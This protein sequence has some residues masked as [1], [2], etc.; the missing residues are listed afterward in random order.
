MAGVE[1]S[2]IPLMSEMLCR[3]TGR[4]DRP[5]RRYVFPPDLARFPQVYYQHAIHGCV[6]VICRDG[7]AD[8]NVVIKQEREAIDLA[9]PP[10]VS[11]IHGQSVL[12]RTLRGFYPDQRP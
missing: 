7:L 3:R 5:G 11:Q 12:V 9:V 4:R 6:D 2:P 10:V 1:I 8:L